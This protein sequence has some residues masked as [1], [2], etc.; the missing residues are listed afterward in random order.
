MK[1]DKVI[2]VRVTDKEAE[3][4]KELRKQHSIN[5]SNLIRE[6]IKEYYEKNKETQ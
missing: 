2:I 6:F 1:K 3:M 5:I 4:V